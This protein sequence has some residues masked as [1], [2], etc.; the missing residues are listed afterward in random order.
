MHQNGLD[1]LEHVGPC[2]GPCPQPEAWID[3]RCSLPALVGAI[4]FYREERCILNVSLQYAT[5]LYCYQQNTLS[6]FLSS[7]LS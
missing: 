1:H 4:S 2:L 6:Q 5:G 3:V 7:L